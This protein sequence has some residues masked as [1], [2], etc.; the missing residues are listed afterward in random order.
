[1]YAV[2]GLKAGAAAATAAGS[3]RRDAWRGGSASG[4]LGMESGVMWRGG[5][6]RLGLMGE[7]RQR[8]ASRA[9]CTGAGATCCIT[10]R[11]SVDE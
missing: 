5:A 2:G 7:F 1:M 3:G 11:G 8:E 4:L 9:A 6:Q 10:A